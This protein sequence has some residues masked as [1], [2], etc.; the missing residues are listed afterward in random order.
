MSSK[1]PVINNT[2]QLLLHSLDLCSCIDIFRLAEAY[3]SSSVVSRRTLTRP[4]VSEC[5]SWWRQVWREWKGVRGRDWT[6]VA[7]ASTCKEFDGEIWT[8]FHTIAANPARLASAKLTRNLNQRKSTVSVT[9]LILRRAARAVSILF[10]LFMLR[11]NCFPLW[12]K[13]QSSIGTR[14]NH[15]PFLVCKKHWNAW[16]PNLIPRHHRN[17]YVTRENHS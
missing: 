14:L 12:Q 2:H 4:W 7:M 6:A 15:F 16:Q 13:M 11:I 3:S 10:M 5:E 1:W 17:L 8:G 9:E